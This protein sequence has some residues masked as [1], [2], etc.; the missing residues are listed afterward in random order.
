MFSAQHRGN[1]IQICAQISNTKKGDMSAS[2]YYHKMTGLADTMDNIG[3]AMTNEDVIVY[4]LA[5][6]GPGHGDLFTFIT[7]LSNQREVALPEF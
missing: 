7:V 4:I 2:E 5:G 6:L 1:S 3:H